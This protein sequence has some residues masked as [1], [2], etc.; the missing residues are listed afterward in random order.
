MFHFVSNLNTMLYN[1]HRLGWTFLSNFIVIFCNI[2]C[3]SQNAKYCFSFIYGIHF[4]ECFKLGWVHEN[5]HL[6]IS[7]NTQTCFISL[8]GSLWTSF[9][10]NV[11][12]MKLE[13]FSKTTFNRCHQSMTFN[14]ESFPFSLEAMC[15]SIIQMKFIMNTDNKS[16][17]WNDKLDLEV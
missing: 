14:F 5:W 17:S 1:L 10:L 2:S 16:A 11:R 15:S 6:W 13:S 4:D 12:N 7:T 3:F 9:I 8:Y